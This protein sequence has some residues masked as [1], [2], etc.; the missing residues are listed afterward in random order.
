V[1]QYLAAEPARDK[2]ARGSDCVPS[3]HLT[4]HALGLAAWLEFGIRTSKMMH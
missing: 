2:G 3:F 4:Q 1:A